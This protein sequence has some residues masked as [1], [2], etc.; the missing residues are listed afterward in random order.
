MDRPTSAFFTSRPSTTAMRPDT[1]S[2]EQQKPT[3]AG[4]PPV[5]P[6]TPY[7]F[8][9]SEAPEQDTKLEDVVDE[10][11]DHVISRSGTP[12]QWAFDDKEPSLK[13][14]PPR[15]TSA[16]SPET[17]RR[18]RSRLVTHIRRSGR[19]VRGHTVY[20]CCVGCCEVR[21]RQ[22]QPRPRNSWA[23]CSRREAT[24]HR[25]DDVLT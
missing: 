11:P 1:S 14:A 7:H 3:S 20:G 16:A 15:P 5:P 19:G 17:R 22:D 13:T 6:R 24:R 8:K 21:S 4:G 18:S 9:G 2:N 23:W 10:L 25:K 12:N